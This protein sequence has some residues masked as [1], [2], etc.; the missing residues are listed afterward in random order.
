MERK[1]STN[2]KYIGLEVEFSSP[3]YMEDL[4]H[5]LL[6]K[7]LMNRCDISNDGRSDGGHV[8]SLE[9]K[10]LMKQREVSR[11]VPRIFQVLKDIKATTNSSHGIHVHLD[12]RR[13]NPDKVYNNLVLAQD[14][15]FK[16][17]GRHR[18]GNYYCLPNKSPD[19]RDTFYNAR[20]HFNA[21]SDA[22]NKHNTME[23]RIRE[24]TLDG[25][26]ILQWIKTLIHISD[27]RIIKQPAHTYSDLEKSI[28]LSNKLK[29]Y[30]RSRTHKRKMAA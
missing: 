13:R 2:D 8:A 24:S 27:A 15:L 29:K 17:C 20:N 23:V 30:I 5:I 28:K 26:D 1:P 21:I 4:E 25:E 19:L 22:R 3:I 16:M 18:R 11:I 14:V 12:V 9:L 10:V 7:G 6:E